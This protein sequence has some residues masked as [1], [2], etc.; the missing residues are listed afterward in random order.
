MQCL[1]LTDDDLELQ[2][3]ELAAL[4]AENEESPA[5][6]EPVLA[7]RQHSESIE[8]VLPPRRKSASIEPVLPPRRQSTSKYLS[9]H[10]LGAPLAQSDNSLASDHESVKSP[11]SPFNQELLVDTPA[12][13]VIES[14]DISDALTIAASYIETAEKEET[15]LSSVEHKID[16][17]TDVSVAVLQEI[18]D[19]V[20]ESLPMPQISDPAP[21]H[22]ELTEDNE[23]L[24]EP[25]QALELA[26]TPQSNSELKSDSEPAQKLDLYSEIDPRTKLEQQ[27][28]IELP[29]KSE[30]T[31]E[32][33]VEPKI[34]IKL[35]P[36]Q[37]AEPDNAKTTETKQTQYEQQELPW[38]PPSSNDYTPTSDM[39]PSLYRLGAGHSEDLPLSMSPQPHTAHKHRLVLQTISTKRFNKSATNKRIIS[40]SIYE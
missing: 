11:S 13:N 21:S 2:T 32:T 34:E 29:L 15:Q 25:K 37:V 35:E 22:T 9:P 33:K 16:T 24:Y 38:R 14:E 27:R 6:I 7:S 20:R 31:T 19:H 30:P 26:S 17:F 39:P 36:E 5:N 12:E 10:Y 8:P 3:A 40:H 28:E 23:T 18:I 4:E 1:H